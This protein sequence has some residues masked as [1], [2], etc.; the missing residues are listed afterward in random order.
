RQPGLGRRPSLVRCLRRAR[1]ESRGRGGPRIS[2]R[3]RV[4][5]EPRKLEFRRLADVEMRS[6]SWLEKPLWQRA[7]FQLVAGMKG[8]GKGTYVAG[9]AARVSRGEVFDRPMNVLLAAA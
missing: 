1:P 8:S 9:L 4:S 2:E 7:A 6:I 5:T 3:C